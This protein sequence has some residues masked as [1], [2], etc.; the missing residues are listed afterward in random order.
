MCLVC[1]QAESLGLHSSL[2]PNALFTVAVTLTTH[3]RPTSTHVHIHTFI[4]RL[5]AHYRKVSVRKS[6]G[7]HGYFFGIVT[8][9]WIMASGKAWAHVRYTDGACM[10][11]YAVGA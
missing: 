4:Q 3:P 5:N 11:V 6:F 10:Y 8:D 1:R 7:K 9:V 2:R